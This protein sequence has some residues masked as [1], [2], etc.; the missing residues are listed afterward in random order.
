MEPEPEP[1]P[2]LDQELV[3]AEDTVVRLKPTI[4]EESTIKYAQ[5][6]NKM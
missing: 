2:E 5:Y 3:M 4:V 6:L 1:E